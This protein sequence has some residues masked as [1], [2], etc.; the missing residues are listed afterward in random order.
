MKNSKIN[1]HALVHR[2]SRVDAGGIPFGPFPR[3]S[4]NTPR[5]GGDFAGLLMRTVSGG[6]LLGMGGLGSLVAG[7][8]DFFGG[9]AGAP[10]PLVP[11]Q[12]PAA[13]DEVIYSGAA[14]NASGSYLSQ[15]AQIVEAVKQALLHSSVLNDIIAE[16]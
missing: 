14:A 2:L 6:S 13:Q 11:F 16:I 12:L 4:T 15:D 8:V 9:H 1:L 7:F 3:S 10:P 5:A